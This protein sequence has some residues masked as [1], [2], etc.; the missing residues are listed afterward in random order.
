[1][2]AGRNICIAID[3]EAAAGKSTLGRLLAERL[4]Y[5]Y[6]DTGVMYRAV[7]WVALQRGIDLADE[8]AVAGLAVALRIEVTSP[9]CSDGRGYTVYADGEDVTWAIR[10]PAVDRYVSVV[11]AYAEVRRIL[12]EQQRAIGQSRNVVM[13]GRDIGT[14][15]MPDADVKIYLRASPAERAR[16]RTAELQARGESVT[17]EDVLTS[18]QTRDYTD[19]HRAVHPLRPAD[20]AV[21]VDTD[22]ASPQEVLEL[23]LAIVHERIERAPSPGAVLHSS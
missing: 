15:V 9:T 12:R 5:L 14:A 1:M 8:A 21:I 11:A 3:G 13:V 17:Y 7:T 18:M 22:T 16:R 19:S 2:V 6:F 20:D 4:G 10:D 23:V